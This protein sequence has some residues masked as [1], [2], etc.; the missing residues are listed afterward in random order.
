MQNKNKLAEILIVITGI[1]LIV[2]QLPEFIT[3]IFLFL[4]SGY[5]ESYKQMYL[6]SIIHLVVKIFF[7]LILV[8][9]RLKIINYLDLHTESLVD[10]RNLLSVGVFLLGFH[11]VLGGCI[12][13][14]QFY[15]VTISGYP[16]NEHLFWQGFFS[17]FIGSIA[18]LSSF[19]IGELWWKFRR[20]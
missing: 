14:G 17:I 20:K 19:R 13:L 2:S 5:A 9:T 15:G 10:S 4:N 11:F 18:A 12:A 16:T 7:G 8:I 3:N 1:W 6:L